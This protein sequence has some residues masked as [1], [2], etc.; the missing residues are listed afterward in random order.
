LV[1]QHAV[2]RFWPLPSAPCTQARL[3]IAQGNL[4]AANHW[5]QSSGLDQAQT[6]IS[7]LDEAT[8]LT[9]A[10]LRIAEGAFDVA[11]S[12][13]LRLHQAAATGRNGSLI[14]ILMLQAVTYAAQEQGEKARSILA[15][16][17]R[18]A[19]GPMGAEGYVRLFVD[20]G[21]AMQLLIAECRLRIVDA[22]Q[23]AYLDKLLAAFGKQQ[24]PE[25]KTLSTEQPQI[26]NP[27]SPIQNLIEPLSDRELEV[28]RLVAAGLSNR[29]IA[30]QLIVTVGT[31]K[32]HINHIFG[33][34]GVQSRTQAIVRGQTCG[35]L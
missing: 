3:W 14:E 25:D 28:L 22:R 19:G 5:A 23:Q 24:L 30:E 12:L 8:Y 9:V 13:L 4:A 6:P 26:Q 21:E 1:E 2:S 29:Q 34:L 16:A 27:K 35:L 15:Q 20:E 17:L 7:Y 10:R 32:T 31:V 18:L 33:K 11:G